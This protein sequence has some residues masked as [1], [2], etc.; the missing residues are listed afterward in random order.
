[1]TKH[2]WQAEEYRNHSSVQYNAAME[3]LQKVS[4]KEGDQVLDI[5]CG[6]GKIT[7]LI[8][9]HL[10]MGSILGI[11]ISQEMIDFA[12]QSFPKNG[13]PNLEFSIQDAEKLDYFEQFDIIVSSFAIQWVKN[14]RAFLQGAYRSLKPSGYLAV[15][16]PLGISDPLEQAIETVKAQPEWAPYFQKFNKQWN[17]ITSDEFTGLLATNGFQVSSCEIIDQNIMF[18]SLERF[19]KYVLQWF[20]YLGP[21]PENL[22]DPFFRE[23]VDQYLEMEPILEDG[24][25]RFNFSRMDII[26]HKIVN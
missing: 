20:P 4:F 15:T 5:G 19:K 22:R 25:V 11:D 21:L 10:K 13:N 12:K 18:P 2:L 26:A 9:N 7:A 24:R 17:F 23:I 14:Q 16:I 1:M 6:D 8:A 3:L